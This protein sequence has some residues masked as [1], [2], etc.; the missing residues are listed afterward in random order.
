[1]CTR[2]SVKLFVEY[3]DVRLLS[4]AINRLH[5]C[6]PPA[7]FKINW[8]ACELILPDR[9]ALYGLDIGPKIS[10]SSS[11]HSRLSTSS[12][13]DFFTR[14]FCDSPTE[15]D[16]RPGCGGGNQGEYEIDFGK[17]ETGLD[18]RT[19]CMVRNIP[20]K[21]TQVTF[22]RSI[23]FGLISKCSLT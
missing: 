8:K 4:S 13:L 5:K 22:K 12:E 14:P 15:Y 18:L 17:I 23:L 20:N 3:L 9:Q 11:G 6:T 19:T 1:M 21:Y 7:S 16:F 2:S 10:S